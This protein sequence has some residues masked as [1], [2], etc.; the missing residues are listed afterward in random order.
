LGA[1]VDGAVEALEEFT[2]VGRRFEQLGTVRGVTV[3][4]DYAHHPSEV[5][6]TL[7]AA[8]QRFPAARLV[9]A[10]Q[11]HLYSRTRA[12]G[13]A[14]GIAL[15]MADVAVVT[16]IYPAREKP[17]PGVTGRRVAEA[18]RRAGAEVEWVGDLQNLSETLERLV[19]H[20]DV[21]LTLGAGDITSVGRE[22]LKRLAD[23]A[24]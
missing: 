1:D 10:F 20:G 4:D 17:I 5:A 19:G 9:A 11:P 23:R 12:L 8:R 15:A 2:G 13:D 22:L 21:V 16:E 18:A 24:A 14:M 7:G 3:V 6:A